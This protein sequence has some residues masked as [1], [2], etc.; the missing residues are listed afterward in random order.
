MTDPDDRADRAGSAD[1][2]GGG[3]AS[4][5]DGPS[6]PWL[7]NG[8]CR[9]RQ[10]RSLLLEITTRAV[11]PTVLVFSV[12]LLLVGHYGPGGGFSAGLVA[13][14]AFVLR[15]IAGGGG[16]LGTG[17]VVRP[18]TVFGTGMAVAVLSALLPLAFGL[19]VLESA[20]LGVTLPVLGTIEVQTSLL[21]EVGVYLLIVGVVLELLRSLGTGIER[22]LDEAGEQPES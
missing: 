13:G 5:W 8:D 21:L 18:P 17:R 15:H 10:H 19:G 11:F 16:D 1:A 6:Q 2:D 14:L 20:K 7:L 3:V 9:G 12:Y 22:D 4:T